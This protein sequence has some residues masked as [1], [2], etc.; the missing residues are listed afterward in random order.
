MSFVQVFT[1]GLSS[2]CLILMVV[3]F[4]QL[5][6][7]HDVGE[8]DANLGVLLLEFFELYGKS[9]D[10]QSLAIRVTGSGSYVPKE[11]I[12]V[13]LLCLVWG[14]V[15]CYALQL[16]FILIEWFKV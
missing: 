4:L 10:Y 9:F 13:G 5:H 15:I 11:E 14:L 2:Y 12:Q 7:R 6:A 1:G 16:G 8:D 3:S